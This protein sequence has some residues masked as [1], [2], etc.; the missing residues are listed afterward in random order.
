MKE[1]VQ[2]KAKVSRPRLRSRAIIC[3]SIIGKNE[4]GLKVGNNLG[5][6]AGY[7][8]GDANHAMSYSPSSEVKR[9]K[10]GKWN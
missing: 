3:S 5:N 7:T 10:L 8:A 6:H 2:G 9:A 1:L 4:K